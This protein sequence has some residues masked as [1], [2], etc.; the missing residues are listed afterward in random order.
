MQTLT[1]QNAITQTKFRFTLVVL[2]LAAVITIGSFYL[3][4]YLRSAVDRQVLSL[5]A[6]GYRVEYLA[7]SQGLGML[8]AVG[9][10]FS[11]TQ[12]VWLGDQKAEGV[13]VLTYHSIIAGKDDTQVEGITV[14]SFEG[15]NVSLEHFK[16]QMF[17]LK[18]AGWQTVRYED[19]DAYLHGKK[20]LPAKSF[21]ITFDDGA[22]SSFYP[23]DPIL[24][25]LGFSAVAFILPSHS[26]G[27][28]SSYYL[29]KNELELMLSTGN[30][31]IE[32]HGQDIHTALPSNADGSVRDN[33][34][35]NRAWLT[36]EN[37]LETHEE[38]A[39]RINADLSTSKANL[40]RELHV[41]VSGFAFPFGDYGQNASN[42]P[43]GMETVLAAARENYS[44]AFYQNWNHG[45]FSFNYPAPDAFLV[46]RIP[47]DPKW[48]G[49][50]LLAVLESAHPKSLPYAE[51]PTPA[52]GWVSNWGEMK[53]E[54]GTMHLFA[55]PNTTGAIALLD[56]S[57]QW[58]DYQAEAE[59]E[60][61]KGY[62]MILFG[63]QNDRVGRACVFSAEEGTVQLQERTSEDILIRR[64]TKKLKEIT[65][66]VHTIGAV[67]S[68]DTTACL[69]DG[70][71]V[72]DATLPPLSGGIALE[73][74]ASEPGV[75]EMFIKNISVTKK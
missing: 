53:V 19:F 35:S 5:S 72:I 66:G 60:W 44:L 13:P 61:E 28:R 2:L 39:A 34:L 68:G 38:Y 20:E 47:V 62:A 25:A 49:E 54:S 29:N 23:V 56:G 11:P 57:H 42:D 30:W 58:H 12:R 71:Y 18:R 32:S 16:E 36:S 1:I 74:W 31:Q 24:G 63:M 22:K 59:V 65:P 67:T 3:V 9:G 75:A 52:S 26:L 43:D 37:R 4:G 73:A 33:A 50:K 21:V 8:A 14:S 69:F 27:D 55:S 7:Q 46:K 10:A 70:E 17:A 64:E 6:L 40:E 15:A 45:D 51:A 41:S 48:D